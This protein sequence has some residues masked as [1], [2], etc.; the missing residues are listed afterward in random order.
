VDRRP[1]RPFAGPEPRR[2]IAEIS[3][4][5]PVMFTLFLLKKSGNPGKFKNVLFHRF[6]E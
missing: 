2:A 1:P 3:A 6:S 5:T 4:V